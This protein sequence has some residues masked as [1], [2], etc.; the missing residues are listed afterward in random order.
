MP[1]SRYEHISE[2]V[3]VLMT[4]APRSIL[5][6]GCGFGRWGFLAREF[7][8]IF[9][10]RYLKSTWQARVDAVEVFKDY[11]SPHH[12]YI[13]NNVYTMKIEDYVKEMPCYDVIILGDVIEHLEKSNGE[14]VLKAL[15]LKSNKALIIALPLGNQWPQ[16]DVFGNPYETHRSIWTETDLKRLGARYV[17]LYNLSDGRLYAVSIWSDYSL[18]QFRS[19]DLLNR[20]K[21]LICR[22][23]D[24]FA[25]RLC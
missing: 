8:D 2:V 10:G 7:C 18:P 23:L 21:Q 24:L 9:Q 3:S 22:L 12:E 20:G 11:L 17:K 14:T 13:Y 16:E 19:S 5:D 25:R 15:S 4:L 6:V 1:S